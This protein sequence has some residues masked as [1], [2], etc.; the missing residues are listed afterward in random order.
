MLVCSTPCF[1]QA[2]TDAVQPAKQRQRPYSARCFAT[3]WRRTAVQP[4]GNGPSS[5]ASRA[6]GRSQ[7]SPVKSAEQLGLW[8]AIDAAATLG[9]IAGALAFIITSEALLAGIPV[10]LPLVAWYAGRQKENLQ[11]EVAIARAAKTWQV[12]SMSPTT[13]SDS[14]AHAL[15]QLQKDSQ[16]Q[17]VITKHV[18]SIEAKLNAL[19]GS[20]LTAGLNAQEAARQISTCSDQVAQRTQAQLKDFTASIQSNGLAALQRLDAKLCSVESELAELKRAQKQVLEASDNSLQI[21]FHDTRQSLQDA[22]KLIIEHITQSAST[23]PQATASL[24]AQQPGL[25]SGSG[26][27]QPAVQVGSFSTNTQDQLRQLMAEELSQATQKIAAAQ[28]GTAQAFPSATDERFVQKL[29]QIEHR[30]QELQAPTPAGNA[31]DASSALH[32]VLMLLQSAYEKVEPESSAADSI[33]E[34]AED[35]HNLLDT[36]SVVPESVSSAASDQQ[37]NSSLAELQQ[38]QLTIQ[39]DLAALQAALSK[40][41]LP[42]DQ[43]S[44]QE[45]ATSNQEAVLANTE[46]LLNAMEVFQSRLTEQVNSIVGKVSQLFAAQSLSLLPANGAGTFDPMPK[47]VEEAVTRSAENPQEPIQVPADGKE[48]AYERMQV[49]LQQRNSSNSSASTS[50]QNDPTPG[51]SGQSAQPRQQPGNPSGVQKQFMFAAGLAAA[52]EVPLETT[53]EQWWDE[54]SYLDPDPSPDQQ[55]QQQT[56]QRSQQQ[57]GQ[58]S[59]QGSVQGFD[60]WIEPQ[61]NQSDQTLNQQSSQ[62]SAWPSSEADSSGVDAS[63]SQG[64]P[65]ALGEQQQSSVSQFSQPPVSSNSQAVFSKPNPIPDDSSNQLVNAGS[66]QSSGASSNRAEEDIRLNSWSR[67]FRDTAQQQPVDD[68]QLSVDASY[69]GNQVASV[70]AAQQQASRSNP[71]SAAVDVG[72]TDGT[73][74]WQDQAASVQAAQKLNAEDGQG[75][76]LA[77]QDESS[78]APYQNEL[79]DSEEA[80]PLEVEQMSFQERL[81]AGRECFRSARIELEGGSLGAASSLMSAALSYFEAASLLDDKDVK[82]MGSWGNALLAYGGLKKRLLEAVIDAPPLGPVEASAVAASKAQILTEASDALID[83]GHKFQSIAQQNIE[84]TKALTNWAKSICIRASLKD[85]PEDAMRLYSSAVDKFEKVL[86]LKPDNVS[87]LVTCGLALKD[88]ALCMSLDDPDTLINLEDA[89]ICMQQ[90]LSIDSTNSGA[91]AGLTECQDKLRIC[92]QFNAQ[93]S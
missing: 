67:D 65:Q 61:Q 81:Q 88:M 8:T 39:G 4:R 56:G 54:Q 77:G 43:G 22:E 46:S 7:D 26:N 75:G 27:G 82:L 55:S 58:Q 90:A 6:S 68:Q 76:A 32:A 64:G 23:L 47:S 50:G 52:G 69:L 31:Q 71:A 60:Q 48:T 59:N 33:A 51:L 14:I 45:A 3:R 16:Q 80:E 89:E 86:A 40:G 85:R 12:Q 1:Y 34:A 44:N 17:Q 53:E 42:I 24:L 11:I 35:L 25:L 83:A 9:S 41:G 70:Q 78:Q 38:T 28:A 92:M 2:N 13:A 91:V 57:V 74:Y 72:P 15:Q 21:A 5:I 62:Q 36:A 79:N 93:L 30:L 87:V 84:D 19:E 49:L 20:V 10:V 66:S 73:S 63:S 18:K 37:L 29:T